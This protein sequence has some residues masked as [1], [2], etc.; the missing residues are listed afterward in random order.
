MVDPW[1]TNLTRA[2][3]DWRQAITI[4]ANLGLDVRPDD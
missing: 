2:I 1:S 4:A 3:V